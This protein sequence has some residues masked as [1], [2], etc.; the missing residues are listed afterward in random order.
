[1]LAAFAAFLGLDGG[2]EIARHGAVEIMAV[3]DSATYCDFYYSLLQL[4]QAY[5]TACE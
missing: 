4:H 5:C 2:D 1:M 3:A